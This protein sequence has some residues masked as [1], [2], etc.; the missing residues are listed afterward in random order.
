MQKPMR[1][2]VFITQPVASSAV[3]RLRRVAD[4]HLNPDP[5]H[6]VSKDELLAA[7]RAHDVLFC[8]LHDRID[9]DVI[10]ANPHLRVIASTTITP[11]DIDIAEATRRRIPVTV[12]PS[13]LLDDATADLAWALLF[14]V[15][16]R[17][18]EADR[19]ARAGTI[20]GSQSSYLEAGGVSGRTLGLIGVG[21][22]GRAMAR[23]ASGFPLRVLYHDPRRLAAADEKHLGLAWTPFDELLASSD[24]VSIHANLS[25]Q[26][27]HLL[28]TR[29]FGL[30]K[31]TACLIN[32]ARGPIVDERA[33]IRALTERRIAG[34]GLDV[35]EHEPEIDRALLALPNTVI[36]PHMGSAVK[37]LRAAMAEVAVDNILAVIDG[38]RPPNCWNPEIFAAP[39]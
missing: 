16:R 18:A 2:R 36:T 26:T 28:S 19:L 4:V 20:P 38:Q 35:F 29:E 34:A 37:E 6:I 27:R 23:R 24:F 30:M 39:K 5:L 25:A 9:R 11:A 17:V 8:L 10:A 7:V 31:P 21:G 32:T 1:P 3:E 15:G 14:A 22:V 33:L 13:H 12:I